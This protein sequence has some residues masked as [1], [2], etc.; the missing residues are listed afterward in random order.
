MLTAAAKALD[1]R[2]P[3][4]WPVWRLLVAHFEALLST[5]ARQPKHDQ[6]RLL[7]LAPPLV[8]MLRLSNAWQ[9]AERL[10]EAAISA[11][12]K[13]GR[14]EAIVVGVQ[15]NLATI[16]Q[17]RGLYPESERLL[18]DVLRKRERILGRHHR[19]TAHTRGNLA[20]VLTLQGRHGEALSIMKRDFR[21]R[22]RLLGPEHPDTH[23]TAKALLA[24]K[25]LPSCGGTG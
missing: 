11:A 25:D 17:C 23:E 8:A 10:G 1:F 13:L 20:I 3:S 4:H 15:H 6:R 12:G 24:A 21:E 18:R 9:E 5:S 16:L 19:E 22:M 14:S 2:L 7:E